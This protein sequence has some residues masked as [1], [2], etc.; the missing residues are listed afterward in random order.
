MGLISVFGQNDNNRPKFSDA[1][2]QHAKIYYQIVIQLRKGQHDFDKSFKAFY[3]PIVNDCERLYKEHKKYEAFFR[4]KANSSM[5]NNKQE[6]AKKQE[7]ARLYFEQLA[8]L[9]QNI[10]EAFKKMDSSKIDN[11]LVEYKQIEKNLLALGAKIPQRNWVTV[12]EAEIFVA[13]A[14]RN[15]RPRKQSQN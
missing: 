2:K 3:G 6:I 4:Q 12:S 8:D 11:S 5:E 13:Q 9:T 10:S 14:I 7:K 1:Q 15:T